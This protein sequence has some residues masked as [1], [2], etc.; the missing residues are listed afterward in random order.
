M[1]ALS[2]AAAETEKS[3]LSA[4]CLFQF[5]Y[6]ASDSRENYLIDRLCK[7]QKCLF[8]GFRA[9]EHACVLQYLREHNAN[10]LLQDVHGVLFGKG[11][12]RFQLV[13]PIGM[14]CRAFVRGQ[15]RT[16]DQCPQADS[17]R[18]GRGRGRTVSARPARRAVMSLVFSLLPRCQGLPMQ[19]PAISATG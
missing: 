6:F 19:Q 13:C 4:F 16:G 15:I 7:P 10:F 11:I 18:H 1:I 9:F 8:A 12:S 5:V 2:N 14:R 17:D 3:R